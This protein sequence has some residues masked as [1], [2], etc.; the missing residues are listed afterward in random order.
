VEHVVFFPAQDG[1]PAFRRFAGLEDAVRFV[2]HLRNVENVAGASVYS[3]TEIP[4]AFK[5]WYR[6][7]LPAGAEQEV[8]SS[9]APAAVATE[10]AAEAAPAEATPAEVLAEPAAPAAFVPAAPATMAETIQSY[11]NGTSGSVSLPEAGSATGIVVPDQP[12][13]AVD[14]FTAP[15]VPILPLAPQVP[16]VDAPAAVAA[17]SSD[18]E[19]DAQVL[20]PAFGA[21]RERGLGFFAH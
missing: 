12:L 8:N 6:V 13:V 5:A 14:Q 10:A 7:E 9:E 2:E 3:L 16:F 17:P 21:R 1:T 15:L 11:T 4:L 19:P 20:E 18:I